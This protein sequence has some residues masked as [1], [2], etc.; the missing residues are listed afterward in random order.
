MLQLY[1]KKLQISLPTQNYDYDTDKTNVK[2]GSIPK[3]SN[4]KYIIANEEDK[5]KSSLFNYLK[6]S[7]QQV[8]TDIM[9]NET[10]DEIKLR[11]HSFDIVLLVDTKETCG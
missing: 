8:M 11:P 5:E 6:T 10:Q 9:L 1:F 7:N 2:A 3:S 4:E